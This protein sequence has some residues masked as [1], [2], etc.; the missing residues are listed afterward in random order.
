MGAIKFIELDH[1]TELL[2][3]I[4]KVCKILTVFHLNP[5]KNQY[6]MQYLYRQFSLL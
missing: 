1:R 3:D 4:Q 5:F 6:P 2:F